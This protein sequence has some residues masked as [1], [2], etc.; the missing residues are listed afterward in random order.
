MSVVILS[1]VVVVSAVSA[2]SSP[3]QKPGSN[4]VRIDACTI[5]TPDMVATFAAATK[6]KVTTPPAASPVGVN[7]SQCDYG[8]IALHINPFSTVGADRMRKS[9]GSNWVPVTGVGDA[10]FFHNV[11]NALAELF[12]WS[13]SHHFGILI[14]VPAGS[15]A[16]QLKPHVIEVANRIVPK[17][18]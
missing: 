15:A 5:L 4:P 2:A 16:E 6:A 1:L 9:P 7:G 13:G 18:R 17:L 11:Q 10:A 14:D 3:H 12:V 8:G